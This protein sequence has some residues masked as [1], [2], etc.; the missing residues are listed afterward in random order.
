MKPSRTWTGIVLLAYAAFIGFLL[1]TV[2]PKIAEHYESVA[3]AGSFW[4]YLYLG[5]ITLGGLLFLGTSTYIVCKLWSRSRKK[6]QRKEDRNKNPSQ[7]SKVQQEKEIADNLDSIND[8]ADEHGFSSEFKKELSPLV[9]RFDEKQKSQSLEIVAFGTVSSGKSSLLN[10]LAGRDVFQTDL[11][12]GTT[13]QRNE[14]AWPSSDKVSLV[15]TPGLGEIEGETRVN[16]SA[17]AAKDADLV[18]IVVDGPLRDHEF[19]LIERLGQME[20][21]LLLC[22]NKA[23]WYEQRDQESLLIQ[24]VE[25]TDSLVPREDVLIVRAKTTHRMRIRQSPNGKSVEE[26]VEMPPDIQALADRML[27]LVEESGQDLLMANLLL[28][29]RGLVEKAKTKVKDT[30][31]ERAWKIVERHMWSAGSAAAISPFPLV[32]LAAG[33]AISTKMVVDLAHV[34]RQDMDLEIATNLL[35][36]LGKNLIGILGASVA[37][38]VVAT[39]IASLLKT[40]PGVGTIAGGMLQGLV[41]ALITRWIGAVF[42]AFFRDEMQEPEGGFAALAR[43]QWEKVTSVQ[44]LRQLVQNAKENFNEAETH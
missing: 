30:L 36:Q 10:L 5:S 38:P 39:L 29:S 16:I 14:I 11:R 23:D 12:G 6:S 27:Q 34:Y 31:D 28:Q 25:Q 32:D 33:C 8:L 37:T 13:I 44:E 21:R 20:K 18:L 15:D 24:L 42:I 26:S 43:R 4:V 7:L 40:V 17:E 1:V 22:L 2:P 35:G 9:K 3:S 41:Q 19:Q